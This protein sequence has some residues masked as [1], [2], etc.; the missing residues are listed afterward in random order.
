MSAESPPKS[1]PDL[2][3]FQREAISALA[4]DEK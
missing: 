4:H 1:L 2:S 3:E